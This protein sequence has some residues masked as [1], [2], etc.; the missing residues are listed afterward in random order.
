MIELILCIIA[1]TLLVIGFKIFHRLGISSFQAIVINYGVAGLIGF[2]MEPGSSNLLL[3]INKPWFLNGCILGMVFILN[4]YIM[5]KSTQKIGASVTS[6]AGKMSL[7]LTVLFSI[8]YFKEVVNVPKIA[9]IIIALTSVFLI[10]QINSK[11]VDKK[12]IFLPIILFFGGGFIDTSLNYNQQVHLQ[13]G[14]TGLFSTITFCSAFI[15][16]F[17]VL[18]YRV[19]L[20]KEKLSFKNI[21][22]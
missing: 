11:Q 3:H 9:G 15:I 13:N 14:G 7:V 1:C 4:F 2:L 8:F 12:F 18:V 21:V 16:G 22:G 5:A 17:I 20:K 6:V 19:L 10:I